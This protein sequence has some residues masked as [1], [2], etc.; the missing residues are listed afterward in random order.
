MAGN[1]A[2]IQQVLTLSATVLAKTGLRIG[3]QEASLTIGGVDNPV[4]RDP[5]TRR[6]YIP[7]SSVKGKMRSLLERMHGLEQNWHI[8]RDRVVVH[9]CTREDDYGACTLCQLFGAPAPERERWLCQ[10]RLRFSDVFMTEDS[11]RRLVEA[12][13]DLPFTELKSEAAI[14]RITSAAVPRTM[15]RVPA[16]T[17]FGPLEIALFVYEGDRVEDGLGW[18]SDGLELLEADGLGSAVARGSGRVTVKDI[19]FRSLM[20]S[21]GRLHRREFEASYAGMAELRNGLTEVA[22]WARG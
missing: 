1:E 4:V 15:E 13:T 5:L 9:V 16:G 11:A 21:G 22:A 2:T 19:R 17:E 12:N 20:L 10:T 18:V 7:G 6:P 3:A 8:Q 14:D